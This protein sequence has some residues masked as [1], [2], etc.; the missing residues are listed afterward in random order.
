MKTAVIGSPNLLSSF[1][2][3]LEYLIKLALGGRQDVLRALRLYAEGFSTSTIA[4][5]MGL[6][7]STV[8]NFI[9]RV[10]IRIGVINTVRFLKKTLPFVETIEPIADGS[11]CIPCGK[12]FETFMALLSHIT[13][14]HKDLI[15]NYVN[16]F[17]TMQGGGGAERGGDGTNKEG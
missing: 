9:W 3:G 2:S 7:K 14:Y 4:R 6:P 13:F 1:R 17:F 15:E 8:Q 11:R 5:M 10:N 12:T 16:Q